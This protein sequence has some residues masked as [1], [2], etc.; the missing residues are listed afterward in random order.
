MV[1]NGN[2][3]PY[4]TP[5][6]AGDYL[7]STDGDVS[8]TDDSDNSVYFKEYGDVIVAPRETFI[9]GYLTRYYKTQVVGYHSAS[10]DLRSVEINASGHLIT[11]VA[12]VYSSGMHVEISGTPVDI[13]GATI[14]IADSIKT[15]PVQVITAGSGG[16]VL[17]SGEI[18]SMCVKA[19][20]TNATD[21]YLGGV[22]HRPYS[23]FGFCLGNGE[24]KCYDVNDFSDLCLC[25]ATSGDKVCFDGVAV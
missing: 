15:G 22:A 25:A 21:I 1:V 23:G 18:I 20:E 3:N 8:W 17:Y 24:V 4:V 14:N 5:Y 19:C 16:Q 7:L 13:S 12:V 9:S 6:A 10:G 2:G 11:D